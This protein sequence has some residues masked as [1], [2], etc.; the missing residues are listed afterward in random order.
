MT[1]MH[2]DFTPVFFAKVQ[3]SVAK[4][5]NALYVTVEDTEGFK[6]EIVMSMGQACDLRDIISLGLMNSIDI[7]KYDNVVKFD[8]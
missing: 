2:I 7:S 4:D 8:G 1:K 6:H 3:A 5:E